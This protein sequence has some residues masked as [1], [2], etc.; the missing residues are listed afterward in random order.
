MGPGRAVAA[1]RRGASAVRRSRGPAVE[2]CAAGLRHR[3]SQ[4]LVRPMRY[5]P[6]RI[7]GRKDSVVP[8]VAALGVAVLSTGV[9]RAPTA[10]P[11]GSVRERDGGARVAEPFADPVSHSAVSDRGVRL[12]RQQGADGQGIQGLGSARRRHA[13]GEV[14]GRRAE[15]FG[16]NATRLLLGHPPGGTR[17]TP[18]G[19]ERRAE[20]RPAYVPLRDGPQSLRG[21]PPLDHRGRSA[22]ERT[23]GVAPLWTSGRSGSPTTNRPRPRHRRCAARTASPPPT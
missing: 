10:P 23:S 5:V 17:R 9:V 2:G 12:P 18:C 11:R 3:G 1:D 13:Q 15:G 7:P 8:V 22:A 19:R 4:E 20:D 21:R 14:R 16:R 6:R